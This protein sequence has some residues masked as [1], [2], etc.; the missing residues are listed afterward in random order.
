MREGESLFSV[1]VRLRRGGDFCFP[2]VA[3]VA[4]EMKRVRR[5]WT[6]GDSDVRLHGL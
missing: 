1:R 5:H 3:F 6:R 2:M 4:P